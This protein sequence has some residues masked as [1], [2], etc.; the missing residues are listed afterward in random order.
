MNRNE[1]IN[2]LKSQEIWDVVIIG[3]GATGLGAAV[4]AASR[5]YST[6]LIE[7]SD[8]AKATS[9]RS[10]KLAHGGIR[11]LQQG[12][13]KLVFE[14]LHERGLMCENAPHLVAHRSFLV[15]NYKWWEGPFYGIGLKVYDLL[16][17]RLGL[18]SSHHISR[19]EVIEKIPNIEQKDLKGGVIYYDGQFD[20]ARYAIALAL[21]CHDLGGTLINY[22]KM[23]QFIK[24][25]GKIKGIIAVDQ[26]TK[27]KYEIKAKVV[28]NAAGI[29]TDVVKK[30]DDKNVEK[31]LM[32]S[33][34]IHI[35]LDK[36][37]LRSETSMLIPHTEDG[38]V[39][40]LVPWHEK[41]LVGTTDTKVASPEM[42]PIA[43]EEEID[44][45]LENA[46]KYLFK[47]PLRTDVLA[48]FAGHRP[49]V[50]EQGASDTKSISREH[51]IT[52]SD[53]GLVSIAGGKWTTYRLMAED[54]IDQA[55]K[56]GKLKKKRCKT[57][58]LK[59]HGSK[60]GVDPDEIPSCYGTDIEIINQMIK[61]DPS[62]KSPICEGLP[63]LKAYVKFAVEN[64]MAI[65]LE[66]VLARRTR[67]LFLDAYA[68][69]DA[70]KTVAI[71][72]AQLLGKDQKWIDEEILAFKELAKNYVTRERY[73]LKS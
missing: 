17:G 67:S 50:K 53:S 45:V 36:S 5:G 46:G 41:V 15:P 61:E 43:Q 1:M 23:D 66:D 27:Q 71:Y 72:M 20:D 14:A 49:L 16:A 34:G 37:F 65:H 4:D 39:L 70:A 18:E 11:Y 9:S 51:V 6:L 10:T 38:R 52:V 55:I 28:I 48:V 32:P 54:V 7:Q 63:Y 68:S 29:F 3:G 8:F 42:E 69:I 47:K 21:T 44:F 56:T 2:R 64:E 33:Q 12:N 24:E 26:E 31:T 62:L 19:E 59:I 57:E 40:F 13:V 58:K 73:V 22:M 35:V 30:V 60:K 25:K